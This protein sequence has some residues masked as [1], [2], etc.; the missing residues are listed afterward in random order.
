MQFLGANR[1]VTGSRYFLDLG[2]ARIMVDCGMFQERKYEHRN[3]DPSPIDV[4]ALDAVLLTHAH[5]D[6][7]G[8]LPRMYAAGC[9]APIFATNPT[10]DLADIML[11]DAAKIQM[12]DVKY[13]KK[14]HK[15]EGRKSKHPYLPLYDEEHAVSTLGFFRG[16]DYYTPTEV[17]EGVMVTFHDAG[18]ILGSSSIEVQCTEAGKE[19]VRIVFSG[20]IGQWGKPI[21]R[22]PSLLAAADFVVME[23]TYGDRSHRDAGEI[24]VQFEKVINDTI[25]RGGNLV[26]PTFAV[27]RAQEITYHLAQLFRENRVPKIPVFLDSPMAADVT[28]VFCKHR[29]VFDAQAWQLI[30][31]GD[32][33]LM[34]PQLTISRSTNQSKAINDVEGPAVIMSTSGMCTAGRIKHH[35]RNNIEDSRS[36]VLFVGYQGQGT[37]GRAIVDGKKVDGKKEVRIHGRQYQVKAQIE[38]IYG[39][40]GHGDREALLRWSQGFR[41]PPQRAFITHGDEDAAMSLAAALRES[42]WDAHVPEYREEVTL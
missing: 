38:R 37:L 39:F 11:R 42:K 20:D 15:R 4:T 29:N 41:Q 32:R 35:L 14:R 8:L 33:P 1:Q 17:V 2:H 27:E 36:T 6:H 3:W 5:I 28:E 22:D 9:N 24:D 30:S 40:S 26:I 12:E 34:F 10:V 21:I 23:S 13:K 25:R 19:P 7:C 31:D 18:H 16:I